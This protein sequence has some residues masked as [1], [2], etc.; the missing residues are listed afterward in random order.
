MRRIFAVV[1]RINFL[2]PTVLDL[3]V[4]RENRKSFPDFL[5]GQY[6]TISFPGHPILKSE[7]SFSLVSPPT[8]RRTIRFGIRIEGRYTRALQEVRPADRV[9]VS[10]PYGKFTFMPQRDQS[11]LMI[12]G[13]IGVTP[14]LSMIR[15]A[16]DIKLPNDITLVYSI[17]SLDDA[18][19]VDEINALESANPHFQAVYAVTDQRVPVGSPRF[20]PGWITADLLSAL[21]GGTVWGRSYFLCGPPSFMKAMTANLQSLGLPARDIRTERFGVGSTALIEQGTPIPK[22]VFAAWGAA[23]AIMLGAIVRIEQNR[24]AIIIPAKSSVTS[25]TNQPASD[26]VTPSS[27][28]API[29]TSTSS[30]PATT[31]PVTPSPTVT[32]PTPSVS[33]PA[34]PVY[35]PTPMPVMPRTRMS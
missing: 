5:P 24:R 35:T 6:A 23:A 32:A 1:Q 14:F 19:Y 12:A 22:Y 4:A 27:D 30:A 10:M 21:L 18:A 25:E 2:T 17:R 11:S 28:P 3:T 34:T 20:V 33:V 15:T 13:G 7:R 8:M 31:V 29:P 16:T 9:M 26:P